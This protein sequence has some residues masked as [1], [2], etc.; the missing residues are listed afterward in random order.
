MIRLMIALGVI[1]A[2]KTSNRYR[3][4]TTRTTRPAAAARSETRATVSGVSLGSAF[5]PAPNPP[6]T[7]ENSVSTT[8]GLVASTRTPVP[9]SSCE[10]AS[11]NWRT[12]AFVAAYVAKYGTGMK[13]SIEAT[14]MICPRLL[15]IM[16]GRI[17]RVSPTTAVTLTATCAVSR[18]KG[19]STKGPWL[20]K[21]ALLTSTPRSPS[22]AA[23]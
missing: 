16:S 10:S 6:A 18:P 15:A 5:S 13:A 12:K 22:V 21:P 7:S 23:A 1:A 19:C 4:P 3:P 11:L 9:R 17:R 8:P 2:R 14:L 20:P